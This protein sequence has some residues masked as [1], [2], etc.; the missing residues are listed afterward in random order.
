KQSDRIMLNVAFQQLRVKGTRE[1]KLAALSA[2]TKPTHDSD[3]VRLESDD[4]H[5]KFVPD[6]A[7]SMTAFAPLDWVFPWSHS[8]VQFKRKWPIGTSK[9][10]LERRWSE[11]EADEPSRRTNSREAGQKKLSNPGLQL[12]RGTSLPAL[13][14]N[15]SAVEP[16]PYGYRSFDR[17]YAFPDSRLCDR[18][19]PQLWD[20]FSDR[21]VYFATLTSTSTSEGPALTVSP[22][23][24]DLHFF[25]GS[26]GAKDV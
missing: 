15:I 25:R 16:V 11:L 8:G 18:P 23:V 4:W 19:R 12:V 24:P 6:T 9:A 26:F 20:A 10:A 14:E 22:Y 21:Q 3:W 13:A 5:G 7:A 2:V 17:K 1:E